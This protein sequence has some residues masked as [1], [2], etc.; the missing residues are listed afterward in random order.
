MRIGTYAAVLG[1]QQQQRCLDVIANNI[2]NANTP[3]YKKDEVRFEGFMS[4]STHTEFHQ[5]ALRTTANSLDIGLQG[6]GFLRVQTDKGV[7]YTRGGNLTLNK[8]KT[9]V[10]VEG[11][12]VL[13]KNG[14][15][16]LNGSDTSLEPRID[17][18]G[19]V[20]DGD[21]A[22][23]TL[24]LVKFPKDSVLRKIQNGYLKP[25]KEEE[26]PTPAEECS[27]QQGSLEEANFNLVEE[28]T[29]MVDTMRV[30]EAYQKAF[31]TANQDLDAQIISKL[32]GT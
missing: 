21:D 18:S 11:W 15:I 30:F 27:V 31:Q 7:L 13:G 12:P 10:T 4:Q 20:F 28:M 25:V 9:L 8:D 22:V 23:D 5:G 14:P 3:G 6:E 17:Q 2:A 32:G 29:R 19:Q 1:S 26:K 16:Q 24:D